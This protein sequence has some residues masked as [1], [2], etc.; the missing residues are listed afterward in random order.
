MA[1][2]MLDQF[3]PTPWSV[4]SPHV[5]VAGSHHPRVIHHGQLRFNPLAAQRRLVSPQQHRQHVAPSTP[6]RDRCPRPR[7]LDQQCHQS[8]QHHSRCRRAGHAL[9]SVQH[10]HPARY[11]RHRLVWSRFRLRSLPSNKMRQIPRSRQCELLRSEP[12]HIPQRCR[13]L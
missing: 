12:N 2:L 4:A 10:G 6:Q 1:R 9:G 3:S 5:L 13:H 8:G 7:F 11:P